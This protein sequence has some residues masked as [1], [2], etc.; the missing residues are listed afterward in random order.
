MKKIFV[1]GFKGVFSGDSS[2][3][4]RFPEE[5]KEL[6]AILLLAQRGNTEDFEL[7]SREIELYGFKDI[8]DLRGAELKV[9]SLNSPS[10]VKFQPYYEE[11]L[12]QGSSLAV[13]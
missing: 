10:G 2:Y 5:G 1:Y 12:E 6:K 13:Y 4:Y 8:S 7:A 3:E 11:A 9:E